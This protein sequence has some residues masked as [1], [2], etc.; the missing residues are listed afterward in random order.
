MAH[1]PPKLASGSR[2]AVVAPASGFPRDELFRGLAWL[3]GRYHLSAR[4]DLL[5]RQGYLAGDDARREHELS[6]AML[7]PDV[8]AIF[9]ARGGYGLTRIVDRLPWDA[10]A[11]SPKW[12]V[13]FSDV[14]AL[15]LE[16]QRRGIASVHGPNVTGLGRTSPSERASL[17]AILE[18]HVGPAFADLRVL[19]PGP[20]AKGS[21]VGGNLTLLGAE[22]AAGA[23]SVPEG[24]VL[25]LE[26]VTERPYRIDRT[27]TA[28]LRGGHLAR[29][30][31]VVFGG[32][33]ECV[34]GP[35]GV[36]IEEVLRE[37]TAGLGVL[38]LAGLPVGH[39]ERNMPIPMGFCASASR[40]GGLSLNPSG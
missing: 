39:D 37:R 9:C 17:L 25:F 12:I 6:S 35:D 34:P 29:A 3:G 27:L 16:A 15:H 18:R 28:L 2:V 13:G 14:T 21:L 36:T 5:L 32:F 26:D 11:K 40:D 38:C 4:T 7:D 10:F 22:A 24:A 1:V 33:T 23:L 20:S 31:A 19:H 8:A 30:A